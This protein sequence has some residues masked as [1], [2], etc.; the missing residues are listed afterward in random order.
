M[1]ASLLARN[2][3]STQRL[4]AV[5]G[6][7][8]AP[9]D[10]PPELD[11]V[12]ADF[13][14]ALQDALAGLYR[15]PIREGFDGMPDTSVEDITLW[16]LGRFAKHPEWTDDVQRVLTDWLTDAVHLGVSD[17]LELI[18]GPAAAESLTDAELVK[19]LEDR[20][21]MLAG[22]G[23]NPSLV[24]T[25]VREMSSELLIALAAG[26]ALGVAL[27]A[28]GDKRAPVRAITIA[29]TETVWGVN[30]GRLA[31]FR[32]N[33][34]THVRYRVNPGACAQCLPYNG[35]SYAIPPSLTIP[36]HPHCRCAWEPDLSG[37]SPPKSWWTGR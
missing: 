22:M 1:I 19:T 28:L 4:L 25:T 5:I 29:A 13:S 24:Q 16:L 33:G 7:R 8:A 2:Y 36:L 23:R 31:A 15:A 9:A 20:A 12:E 18:D 17:G 21:A 3:R 10:L 35:R 30:A 27:A 32:K 11:G 37:W 34:V 26:L 6:E 14:E